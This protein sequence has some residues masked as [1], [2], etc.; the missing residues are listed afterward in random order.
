M[1]EETK[2]ILLA[3]G[4]GLI[5]KR[6]QKM[7]L[8]KGHK[9]SVLSRNPTGKDSY[10]WNP[11]QKKIDFPFLHEIDVILNLS[12][13][14][15]ADKRWTVSRKKELYDSRIGVNEFLFS[16]KE[17]MPKLNQFITSS[18]INCYGYE[19][20]KR[21]HTEEDSFGSDYLSQLV[22][23]WEES[24]DL[25]SDICKVAKIRT[26]VVLDMNGGAM[27]KM[28]TPIRWGI[29]SPIGNGNQ[30]MPW[31]HA[32]DLS[33]LFIH[34]IDHQLSGA[35]NAVSGSVSNKEFSEK[36]AKT[37]N[38]PFWFPSIPSFVMK[39]VFG[40]M[41]S[42]LLK[43]LRASNAKIKSSGYVFTFPDLTLALKDLLK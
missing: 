32:A 29:G 11:A 23:D 24:A 22:K 28:L 17:Q 6:I 14:S 31:I 37:L 35:I 39:L 16:L 2:H 25:F 13:A 8:D 3:G 15:I 41:S 38:K 33:R 5:G 19:D 4:T 20:D 42:M 36:L 30:Q 18:G 34:V 12:G 1:T 43:G 9:V 10:F 7:L 27:V 21:E 26:A 40:E